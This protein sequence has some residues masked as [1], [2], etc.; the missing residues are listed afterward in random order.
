MSVFI[1]TVVQIGQDPLIYADVGTDSAALCMAAYDRF[2]PCGVS[3]KPA[4]E[5]QC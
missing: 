3:A 5:P 2:G 1:V 4:G